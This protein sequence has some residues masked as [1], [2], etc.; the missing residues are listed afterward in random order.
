[1]Y[2]WLLGFPRGNK[3]AILIRIKILSLEANDLAYDYWT[4]RDNCAIFPAPILSVWQ[5]IQSSKA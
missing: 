5:F 1:M 4:R 3:H 2:L